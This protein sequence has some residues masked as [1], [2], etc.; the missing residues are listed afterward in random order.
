MFP[1]RKVAKI[2]VAE[3]WNGDPEFVLICAVR[4]KHSGCG[5]RKHDR[6]TT[7]PRKSAVLPCTTTNEG[8]AEFWPGPLH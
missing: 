8:S 2:L 3:R 1:E 7:Y 5:P 4:V 6:M